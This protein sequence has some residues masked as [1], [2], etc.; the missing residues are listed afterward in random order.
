MTDDDWWTRAVE[1][2]GIDASA[3]EQNAGTEDPLDDDLLPEPAGDAGRRRPRTGITWLL[4][5]AGALLGALLLRTFVVQQ[6]AVDGQSMMGTLH[7]GDRVIVNKLSYRLH[8]PRRGDVVVLE[9]LDGAVEIRDLIKRVIG[10]PGDTV[11]YRDCQLFVNG[12]RVAE[13]YLDPNLVSADRCG[14][15]Q[16]PVEVEPDHVFVMGDN[17]AAS[18][19]SRTELIGQIPFGHLIGRAFVIVWPFSDLHWL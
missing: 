15:D 1:E 17:R 13:P 5:A 6:F 10:I 4:V 11:E 8:E 18:L 14:G 12:Q 7:S 9:N 2:F 16:P 3:V 19:D